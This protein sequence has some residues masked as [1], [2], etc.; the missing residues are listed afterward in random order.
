[1][2]LTPPPL[3]LRIMVSSAKHPSHGSDETSEIQQD[4]SMAV[5]HPHSASRVGVYISEG[6]GSELS[7]EHIPRPLYTERCHAPR[8]LVAVVDT[9]CRKADEDALIAGNAHFTV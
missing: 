4:A 7:G 2:V 6:L 8:R 9:P 1:M 3:E 5:T